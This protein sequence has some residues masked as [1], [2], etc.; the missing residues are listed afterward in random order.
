MMQ[1]HVDKQTIEE[2]LE[3]ALTHLSSVAKE[4]SASQF[5]SA[6]VKMYLLRFG[7]QA[8]RIVPLVDE[9]V[10]L[11]KHWQYLAENLQERLLESAAIATRTFEIYLSWMSSDTKVSRKMVHEA[12]ATLHEQS[13]NILLCRGELN[14][15][16]VKSIFDMRAEPMIE[17]AQPHHPLSAGSDTPLGSH[18]E[19]ALMLASELRYHGEVSTSS[20]NNVMP[21]HRLWLFIWP[22]TAAAPL[23][24]FVMR[25]Y[26]NGQVPF[27]DKQDFI[28]FMA[29]L[30][31]IGIF[32]HHFRFALS[33]KWQLKARAKYLF[34]VCD[35][36][37]SS[38]KLNPSPEIAR[39]IAD[40]LQSH[41]DEKSDARS[42]DRRT[43]EFLTLTASPSST[44]HPPSNSSYARN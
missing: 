37:S 34:A 19:N 8:R 36:I 32:L 43:A 3:L 12:I 44:S 4:V 7:D 26:D 40:A 14:L 24:G 16:R 33:Q 11:K 42:F 39:L 25:F 31:S 9:V 41:D 6:D 18:R 15:L 10:A 5:N 17:S 28:P 30:L 21:S 1:G 38:A 35:Y 27:A 22:M 23:M 20:A 13:D 2:R 29:I